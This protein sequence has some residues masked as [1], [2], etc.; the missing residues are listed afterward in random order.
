MI[1]MLM[2]RAIAEFNNNTFYVHS[3]CRKVM[4]HE[5]E[6]TTVALANVIEKMGQNTIDAT[7]QKCVK[8]FIKTQ[9]H[10][11]VTSMDQYCER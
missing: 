8:E 4:T 9:F 3:V 5:N 2:T 1:Y 11:N 6:E 7:N 10:Q